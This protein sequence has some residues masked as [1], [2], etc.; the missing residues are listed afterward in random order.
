MKPVKLKWK[1]L[2]R[3]PLERHSGAGHSRTEFSMPRY[4]TALNSSNRL[5]LTYEIRG[6]LKDSVANW[7]S[8]SAQ[9]H[10]LF[11]TFAW[12]RHGGFAHTRTRN[13]TIEGAMQTLDEFL[14]RMDRFCLGCRYNKKPLLRCS[15]I[16]APEHLDTNLHYH[17][18]LR[19]ARLREGQDV[20]D[21]ISECHRVWKQLVPGGSLDIQATGT[22]V[23]LAHIRLN[24]N[25]AG[26][27]TEAVV[28]YISKALAEPG[29]FDG[30][31]VAG[32]MKSES[33]KC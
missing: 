26:K 17:G 8:R 29:A 9:P 32:T 28:R 22:G 7:L 25:Q 19:P 16:A 23:T 2:R 11:V 3:L 24:K 30:L 10:D 18:N 1:M 5:D 12:N 20:R 33:G 14:K 4:I 6:T 31:Y 13:V 15:M 21:F 27:S